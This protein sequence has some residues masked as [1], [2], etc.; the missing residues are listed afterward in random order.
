[1]H[2]FP[3]NFHQ[4]GKYSAQIA[5]H[6]TDLRREET[7]TDQKSL[8]ISSLQPDYLNMDSSSAFGRNSDRTNN[9]LKKCTFCGGT[10][11]SAEKC[12]KRIRQEKEKARADDT[13]DN[14]GMERTHRK[15]LDVD[16][17]IT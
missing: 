14:R 1:M 2:I 8:N 3:D 16:L 13:L 6:Q 9:V 17:K 15:I 10:N 5:S 4:D 7:F 11:H 12:F